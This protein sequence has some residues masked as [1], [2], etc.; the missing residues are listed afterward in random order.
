MLLVPFG[1]L[2]AKMC[3]S[4]RGAFA[5]K[6]VWLRF[7][8]YGQWIALAYGGFCKF[9]QFLVLSGASA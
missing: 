7:S 3:Q 5:Y 9:M 4:H 8:S 6:S 1:F 2:V